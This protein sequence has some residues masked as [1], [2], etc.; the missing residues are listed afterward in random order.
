MFAIA[1]YDLSLDKLFLARDRLGIK[2]LYYRISNEGVS[3]AS[4]MKAL[5]GVQPFSIDYSSLYQYLTYQ[6]YFA[7]NT[8]VAGVSLLSPGSFLSF[9]GNKSVVCRYWELDQTKDTDIRFDDAVDRYKSVID[10][11]INRH[12][13]S[14]VPVASYLSAGFDSSTVAQRVA[15]LA[16]PPVV[17]TG[18]F[19]DGTGWYDEA[20]V[21]ADIA[22][23]IGSEHVRVDIGVDDLPRVFDKLVY[24]LDEPRMGMGA[25][26]QYC[27]A[28]R[29][30]QTHKVVLTGH[31]GDELF[32]G[33]PV[34]KLINALY[35][36]GTN[37]LFGRLS[38][39]G[40]MRK[41]ELPHLVYF[42]MSQ[43]K[44]PRYKQFLP[45][46]HSES[47]LKKGLKPEVWQHLAVQEPY[48]AL[49]DL[50]SNK[51]NKEEVLYAH[52][53]QTYLNGLL[54][55]EDKISMAHSLESRTPM[56]DNELLELSLSIPQSV[57]IHG[58][59]LKAIIKE[60]GVGR[61]PNTLYQQPK[62][63]FPTPLRLWL[64][65]ELKEWCAERII[66]KNSALRMLFKEEWLVTT[67]KDFQLSLRNKIRPLDEIN[68]HRM[69]Q[70][71]CL[72]SWLRQNIL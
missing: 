63:G 24:S 3:Y 62:R 48:Q 64:R 70:L 59:K 28:E 61:L 12:M 69:W 43:M 66:G 29:V 71:L 22:G 9:D 65:A 57:K 23:K 17:F 42:L 53:L 7:E 52:Y 20:S 45:V 30:S 31:G 14:D 36:D 2:P 25:F 27:V 8:L 4:E 10:Q 13:L 49:V 11:S 5:K 40:S 47:Q 18:A 72:E 68:S 6:N 50:D 21:A 26:P 44:S 16:S 38:A 46:L 35:G 33:Y 54:I 19:K 58:K 56:L 32:S 60:A 15:E 67:F 39:L 41:A 55:V 37:G 34:F 51:W 1:I